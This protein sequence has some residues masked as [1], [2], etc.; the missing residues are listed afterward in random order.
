MTP[1]LALLVESDPFLF[2]SG[3]LFGPGGPA[4]SAAAV[5]AALIDAHLAEAGVRPAP[6]AG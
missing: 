5:A 6:A 4:V 3:Q 2:V 1:H